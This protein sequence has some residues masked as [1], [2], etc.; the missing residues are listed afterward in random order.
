MRLKK[1]TPEL[2]GVVR[3]R[4]QVFAGIQVINC[5]TFNF[6][7][8]NFPVSG[9]VHAHPTPSWYTRIHDILEA[10]LIEYSRDDIEKENFLDIKMCLIPNRLLVYLMEHR[11]KKPVLQISIGVD[12]QDYESGTFRFLDPLDL[13]IEYLDFDE[14]SMSTA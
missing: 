14:R 4:L 9:S 13:T 7:H 5:F 11:T 2:E 12:V 8:L 3:K 6:P 1:L 10:L